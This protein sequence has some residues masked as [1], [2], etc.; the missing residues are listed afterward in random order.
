MADLTHWK[1]QFNYDYL[2]SYS[3][4]DGKDVV[5]TMQATTREMVV[6][7][8]G[9]KKECFVCHFKEKADWIKPMILN[10]T[11][12][13]TIEKIYGTPYIEEWNGKQITIYI[14]KN[15]KAFND[16]VDALR[17]RPQKPQ[18]PTVDQS[19]KAWGSCIDFMQKGG[20]ISKI[21]EKYELSPEDLEILKQTKKAE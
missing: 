12:C 21:T 14:A 5:L 3:L 20:D 13:K 16:V 18:K 1:N 2:G 6:G 9:K 11:N 7:G 17:I 4:K 8:D 19:H 15:I 10:R